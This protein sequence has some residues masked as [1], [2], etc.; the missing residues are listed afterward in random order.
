[1][2]KNLLKDE[3]TKKNIFF[4]LNFYSLYSRCIEINHNTTIRNPEN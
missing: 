4:F 3:F 1:M 2:R